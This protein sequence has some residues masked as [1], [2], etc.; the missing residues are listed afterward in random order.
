MCSFTSSV[1][2]TNSGRSGVG[3]RRERD[4]LNQRQAILN[5]AREIAAYEGWSAVATRR[6]AERTA[7]THPTIYEHFESKSASLAELTR[8]VYRLL[9]AGLQMTRARASGLDQAIRDTAQAHC[10]FAWMRRQLYKVRHGLSGVYIE[11]GTHRREGEAVIAE[12][13]ETCCCVGCPR[14]G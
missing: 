12:R 6:V 14:R 7:Y 4:E 9:P 2:F 13:Q 10:A 3:A 8:E 11:P 1:E 5:A